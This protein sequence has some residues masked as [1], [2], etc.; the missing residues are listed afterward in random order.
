MSEEGHVIDARLSSVDRAGHG[1]TPTHRFPQV[2][3]GGEG[4]GGQ[5][6]K[7]AVIIGQGV[8]ACILHKI[9]FIPEYID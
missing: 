3:G 6:P 4:R 9:V 7:G 1:K 8:E 5:P 2:E